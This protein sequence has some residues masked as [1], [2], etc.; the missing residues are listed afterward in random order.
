V[1]SLLDRAPEPCVEINPHT[2]AELRLEDGEMVVVETRRGRIEVKVRF[3]PRTL[4]RVI[5]IPH[6]WDQANANVL[7]N[8]ADADPVTGFPA[9][10]A[11]LARITRKGER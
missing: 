10:R 7:T 1:P 11:L 4:P 6:G 3:E 2:A 9:D 8:D 5:S